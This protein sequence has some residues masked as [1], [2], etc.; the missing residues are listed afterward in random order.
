VRFGTGLL[1]GIISERPPT[2]NVERFFYYD[3]IRKKGNLKENPEINLN[4]Q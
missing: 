1:G 2:D 4:Y 3:L